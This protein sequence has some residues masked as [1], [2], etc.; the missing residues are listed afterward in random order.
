MGRGPARS[1]TRGSERGARA[2]HA[3]GAVVNI[4][5]PDKAGSTI[6]EGHARALRDS[7]HSL[8]DAAPAAERLRSHQAH[9][10]IVATVAWHPSPS[11]R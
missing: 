11:A 8:E 4:G 7:T 1:R 9:G 6:S 3:G 2:T 10:K 5:R